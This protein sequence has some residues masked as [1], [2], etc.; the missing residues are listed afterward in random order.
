M[1]NYFAA[2][3]WKGGTMRIIIPV[4]ILF[5]IIFSG[6][7]H[8]KEF[9]KVKKGD[10]LYKIAK[11]FHVSVD[12]LKEIN[13]IDDSKLKPGIKLMLVKDKAKVK[14]PKR[15]SQAQETLR[16]VQ[17]TESVSPDYK[18][19]EFHIVK[20]GDTLA[21]IAR[22]YGVS[23]SEIREIND[24]KSKRL[25]IGQKILLKRTGPR[26]YTVKKGDNIWK[27]AKKYNVDAEEIMEL[28]EL[29]SDELKPGQKL[30]LEAWIDEKELKRYETAISQ[31]KALE[32]VKVAVDSDIT[33]LGVKDR[34]VVFAKKML[35]I[36]YRFG[37]SSFMGIDCS[38]YVQKVFGFL[39][40]PLPRS[41]R[42][43]F[44]IGEPVSKEELNIGD[45]V[46]F[47][48]YASFPS[49]VGIYLGNNLFIHASS[50]SKKVTIDSLDTPYYLKR[51][52]GA[53]R[54]I[55]DGD[56]NH[57]IAVND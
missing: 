50:K 9:Y 52:I 32:D 56:S 20:K 7:A 14:E 42:E 54:I 33:K 35:N 3:R 44:N 37:G 10:S 6:N 21:G 30:I 24:L 15:E 34:V 4:F 31:L 18:D 43:Q 36:P 22:K 55:S 57:E 46:F 39:N 23:L 16:A 49:H 2:N 13:N 45:L 1:F 29:E 51:F 41:A 8:G 53:K 40:I 25:K 48:T 19:S 47:R 17:K 28:N 5:I 12:E 11:K 27:I 26:T 38:G